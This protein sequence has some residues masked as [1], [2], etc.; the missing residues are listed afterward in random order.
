MVLAL[1]VVLAVPVGLTPVAQAAGGPGRPGVPKQRSSEV[2][3]VPADGAAAARRTAVRSAA[4]NA[5]ET[6]RAASERAAS[7]WPAAG[8]AEV[9]AAPAGKGTPTRVGRVPVTVERVGRAA[10]RPPWTYASWTGRPQRRPAYAAC[11]SPRAATGPAPP[12]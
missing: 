5:A 4:R 7:R 2:E 8:A 9:V 1:A 6:G 3:A 12:N 10:A 11:S